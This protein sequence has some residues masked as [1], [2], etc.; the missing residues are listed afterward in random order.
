M[1][2]AGPVVIGVAGKCC[3]GKDLVTDWLRERGL[4]EINVDRLGHR[5][6]EARRD[7]IVS[8][9]GR[10][11]LDGDGTIDRS[12]LGRIVFSSVKRL[13][14]LEAIVHPWMREEVR[15]ETEALRILGPA[16]PVESSREKH[17]RGLIIN[18]A[19]LFHM[20]M[21]TLCDAVILVRA[22]LAAR[23]SRAIRRDGFQPMRILLRLR[24]QRRLETQ[25]RA[26]RADIIS[27]DNRG[28]PQALYRCLEEIPQLQ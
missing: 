27:V 12:K 6:L 4:R 17:P 22:P 25:A 9:F 14:D 20:H 23:L 2:R 26:S 24:S 18:A 7:E 13:R 16:A 11:I 5:A 10:G 1:N 8:V 19:L 28:T 15:R 3:A 21:D